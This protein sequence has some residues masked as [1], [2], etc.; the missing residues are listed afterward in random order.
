MK[1]TSKKRNIYN[2]KKFPGYTL[3]VHLFSEIKKKIFVEFPHHFLLV[4]CQP[5]FNNFCHNN[6]ASSITIFFLVF[7]N[8]GFSP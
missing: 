3:K 5:S 1:T 6:L 7:I 4:F 2:R 8:G